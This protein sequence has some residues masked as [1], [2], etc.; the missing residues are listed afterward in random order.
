MKVVIY[1]QYRENY[2][3]PGSPH[4]KFKGG[5]VY[6]IPNTTILTP[7]E[8]A[9]LNSLINYSNEMAEEYITSI[10]SVE[11]DTVICDEWEAPIVLNYSLGANA[12]YREG[13]WT[14]SVVHKNDGQFIDGIESKSE[15]WTML[16]ESKRQDYTAI[17]TLT[18]GQVLSEDDL[19][20]LQTHNLGG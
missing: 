15:T 3:E 12:F 11:D 19:I 2:G 17:Y 4:W 1:T 20:E 16:P 7:A 6:V 8:R 18:D 5:S 13:I 10:Q 9:E 14:A